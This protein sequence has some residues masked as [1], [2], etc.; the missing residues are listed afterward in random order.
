MAIISVGKGDFDTPFKAVEFMRLIHDSFASFGN[1][2]REMNQ[3]L[4]VLKQ[5]TQK[6]ET[7]CY[8]LQVRASEIPKEMLV[9]L[10][11]EGPHGERESMGE[12]YGGGSMD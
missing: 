3:K 8:N 5:S 11:S 9:E 12:G 2:G 10:F 1:V 4:R 7:A 6:V